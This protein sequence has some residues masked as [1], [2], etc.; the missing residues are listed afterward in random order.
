MTNDGTWG[1]RSQVLAAALSYLTAS[2][3]LLPVQALR[4]LVRKS[5]GKSWSANAV[6]A[7]CS[8]L[9]QFSFTI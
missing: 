9:P 8:Q 5:L 1:F 6:E 3:G 4:F 7:T 2:L